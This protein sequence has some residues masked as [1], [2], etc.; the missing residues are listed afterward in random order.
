VSSKNDVGVG[1]VSLQ[2]PILSA[3]FCFFFDDLRLETKLSPGC[4]FT[5]EKLRSPRPC[6]TL[7]S[8]SHQTARNCKALLCVLLFLIVLSVSRFLHHQRGQAKA[9]RSLSR[10]LTLSVTLPRHIFL[11]YRGFL[12]HPVPKSCF[13]LSHC[14]ILRVFLCQ[15]GRV[16]LYAASLSVGVSGYKHQGTSPVVHCSFVVCPSLK[17]CQFCA[18]YSSD[19]SVFGCLHRCR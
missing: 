17:L 12:V 11:C 2:K 15:R 16:I 3:V 8:A 10:C 9:Q 1:E 13:T 6:P 18:N 5:G 4:A 19:S 7:S 14:V